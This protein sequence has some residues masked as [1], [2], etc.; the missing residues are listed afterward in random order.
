MVT[1]RMSKHDHIVVLMIFGS[2]FAYFLY[3]AVSGDLYIPGKRGPDVHASGLSAWMI[4]GAPLLMYV[5]IIV[6]SGA[7]LFKSAK[8]QGS[9]EILL[10]LSGI[11]LLLAGLKMC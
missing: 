6:R 4:T 3:G 9:I 10:L 8:I 5:G 2:L 1:V 11:A 7:F